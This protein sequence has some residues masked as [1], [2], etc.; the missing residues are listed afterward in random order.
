MSGG[1][2]CCDALDTLKAMV[3][4]YIADC[5]QQPHVMDMLSSIKQGAAAELPPEVSA[6]A[7]TPAT[8]K[9][10]GHDT[11]S[12]GHTANSFAAKAPGQRNGHGSSV[13]GRY[14]KHRAHTNTTPCK[15][16]DECRFQ[17]T[18]AAYAE[19]VQIPDPKLAL[20][21]GYPTAGGYSTSGALSNMM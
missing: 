6:M 16:G 8:P 9:G 10:R 18:V 15:Y 2:E 5:R 7:A 3:V 13:P 4:M 19:I 14:H 20:D 12:K 17:H 11:C 21:E 1:V